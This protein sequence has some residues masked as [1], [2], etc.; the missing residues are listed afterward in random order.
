MCNGINAMMA[1]ITLPVIKKEEEAGQW[2]GQLDALPAGGKVGNSREEDYSK[3]EEHLDHD[4][5]NPPLFRT[6]YLCHWRRTDTD[7]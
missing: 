6:Y 1:K 5:H 2:D 4:S 3:R 7:D